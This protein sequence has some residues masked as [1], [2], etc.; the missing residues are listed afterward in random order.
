MQPP[1]TALLMHLL[2]EQHVKRSEISHF[3]RDTMDLLHVLGICFSLK[4][5][6]KFAAGGKQV[7]KMG[8]RGKFQPGSG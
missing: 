5:W 2:E 7:S 6:M 4:E 8:R 3:S 1:G